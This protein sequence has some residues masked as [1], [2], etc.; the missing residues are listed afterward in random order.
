[1]RYRVCCSVLL[2]GALA[3]LLLAASTVIAIGWNDA[4]WAQGL[5]L[6]SLGSFALGVTVL[7][8][9]INS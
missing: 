1:M 3:P 7:G 6:A 4:E 2:A 5:A 9:R 8:E